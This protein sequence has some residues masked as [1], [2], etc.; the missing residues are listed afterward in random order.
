MDTISLLT[1][2]LL[3]ITLYIIVV[4]IILLQLISLI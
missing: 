2:L 3:E 4:A 1:A